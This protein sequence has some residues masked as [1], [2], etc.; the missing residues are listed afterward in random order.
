MRIDAYTHTRIPGT[1]DFAVW[2]NKVQ[3]D[4]KDQCNQVNQENQC[5]QV[6]QEN[7]KDQEDR[8]KDQKDQEA[9][10]KKCVWVRMCDYCRKFFCGRLW[11]VNTSL[12]KHLRE[13]V[14]AAIR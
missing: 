7:Q 6:D 11:L 14:A 4:R 8:K 2:D 3:K 12:G 1:Q 5:N 13:C 10:Q 9:L